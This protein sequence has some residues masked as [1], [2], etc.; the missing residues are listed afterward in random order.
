MIKF[1]Q[2]KLRKLVESEIA[3]SSRGIIDVG[4]YSGVDEKQG[5]ATPTD[6]EVL[7]QVYEQYSWVRAVVD[8]ITRSVV[9]K[10]YDFVPTKEGSDPSRANYDKLH[11]FFDNVNPQYTFIE[12]LED[13]LRDQLVVGNGYMEKVFTDGELKELWSLDPVYMKIQ[14]DK[15]GKI[16]GYVMNSDGANKVEFKPEEVI[17][18]PMPTKGSQPYG[19]SKMTALAEPVVMD[20]L[21]RKYNKAFFKRGAKLRGII[22]IKNSSPELIERNRRYLATIAKKPEMARG[23]L[24][25]EG[26]ITYNAIGT[27]PADVEFLQLLKFTRDEVL[28][29]YGCPPSKVS[30]IE[31]GNIGSGSG[32]AQDKMFHEETV[33]PLQIRME[34]RI[35]KDLI[36]GSLG[37][38]DWVFQFSK[39]VTDKKE[40]AEILNGYVDTGIMSIEEARVA[41]GLPKI[42]VTE[43][44]VEI[45]AIPFAPPE[46]LA[47]ENQFA[48]QLEEYFAS[49]VVRF[50]E[51]MPELDL[52]AFEKRLK[53]ETIEKRYVTKEFNGYEFKAHR[54]PLFVNKD[55]VGIED[56]LREISPEEIEDILNANMRRVGDTYGVIEGDKLKSYVEDFKY[57]MSPDMVAAIAVSN[58]ELSGYL[59]KSISDEIKVALLEGAQRGES[60]RAI[61]ERVR[62]ALVDPGPI[63]V[64]AVVD[65]AT[66]EVVRRAHKRVLSPRV[67]SKLIARTETNRVMN[68]AS[69]DA[70]KQ[71][72]VVTHVRLSTAV[73]SVDRKMHGQVFSLEEAK[74]KLPLHHNG[75]SV[76]APVVEG[77]PKA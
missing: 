13:A 39:R 36:Q 31:T 5:A 72:G 32:E 64:K 16:L 51:R 24:L 9:S 38:D 62:S 47:I 53:K 33:E 57:S 60:T 34:Q 14:V 68:M 66:E 15:H 28:A 65:P 70:Y 22:G 19:M 67:R 58:S 76:W 77:L 3:K 18:F 27:K 37:I 42:V 43:K 26:E 6:Y 69:L 23:D 71:S 12:L 73:D 50:T 1:F 35:N 29:V 55:L 8:V 30:L 21:A 54:F 49:L 59:A 75:R 17:H 44:K 74:G 52:P 63:Q 10:G 40:Q 20:Q 56:F 7:Y 48:E 2:D 4:D 46:V 25:F 61:T 45:Q 41:I 11:E